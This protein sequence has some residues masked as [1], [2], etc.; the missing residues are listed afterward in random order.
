[1]LLKKIQENSISSFFSFVFLSVFLFATIN[2]LA[3]FIGLSADKKIDSIFGFEFEEKISKDIDLPVIERFDSLYDYAENDYYKDVIKILGKKY[4][5]YTPLNVVVYS[6]DY[7]V[8]E[9]LLV[10]IREKETE[11]VVAIKLN[12]KAKNGEN[13]D[14]IMDG[15][16]DKLLSKYAEDSFV[17]SSSIYNLFYSFRF[18]LVDD[19]N[20]VITMDGCSGFNSDK[21]IL[22]AYSKGYLDNKKDIFNT[23]KDEEFEKESK[24]EFEN[25]LKIIESI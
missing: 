24:K 15:I 21:F 12:V 4:D 14:L 3:S 23:M 25:S 5:E 13:C 2:I 1:M 11:K 9:S 6:F 8:P 7:K 16:K 18:K 17:V 10:V 22:L 20:R 19:V